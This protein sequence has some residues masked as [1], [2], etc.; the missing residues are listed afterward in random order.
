[1]SRRNGCGARPGPRMSHPPQR[2]ALEREGGRGRRRR[3]SPRTTVAP[4][5][6][7]WRRSSPPRP[8]RT[9]GARDRGAARS[10]ASGAMPALTASAMTV[11][12]AM[13]PR[14]GVFGN[15][16]VMVRSIAWSAADLELVAELVVP[17]DVGDAD[18]LPHDARRRR[19]GARAERCGAGRPEA[20]PVG[21]LRRR[22]G[23]HGAL[24]GGSVEIEFRR[25]AARDRGQRRATAAATPDAGAGGLGIPLLRQLC[26]R[27]DVV[28][29]ARAGRA[30]SCASR[31]R[32]RPDRAPVIAA[33]P[34][35][36]CSRSRVAPVVELAVRLVLGADQLVAAR[37][38]R[39]SARRASG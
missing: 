19:R 37:A 17:A 20:R 39:G 9:D 28:P 10:A 23:A 30:G 6:P 11:P 18:S 33:S 12:R 14:A 38:R 24:S 36:W 2:R 4:T 29:A 7:G 26:S 5:R 15:L 13:S 8:H 25:S 1:M 34:A 32:S 31:R 3:R 22:D 16:S 21:G 27:L 35:R